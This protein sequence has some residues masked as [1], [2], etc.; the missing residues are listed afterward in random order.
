MLKGFSFLRRDGDNLNSWQCVAGVLHDLHNTYSTLPHPVSLS[1]GANNFRTSSALDALETPLLP[2]TSSQ[3]LKDN[4]WN[5][6]P[7]SLQD[8]IEWPELP[9]PLRSLRLP[10][11]ITPSDAVESRPGQ[12][13]NGV[14]KRMTSTL[15]DLE[16]VTV[17]YN[18]VKQNSLQSEA[19]L[20]ELWPILSDTFAG[21]VFET[22]RSVTLSGWMFHLRPFQ[23]F[24]TDQASTLRELRMVRCICD[25]SYSAFFDMVE[26]GL[27]SLRLT[28]VEIY[29]MRFWPDFTEEGNVVDSRR[30]NPLRYKGQP[31][32]DWADNWSWAVTCGDLEWPYRQY[33]LEAAM[34]QGRSNSM[35]RRRM[36]NGN[37]PEIFGEHVDWWKQPNYF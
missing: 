2:L 14:F 26:N 16:L 15:E 37:V 21:I 1:F 31:P 19:R 22:L 17:A 12:S 6:L 27:D 4:A 35:R 29:A 9:Q 18:G 23:R 33:E 13:L 5:P 11:D 24:L 28:G 25:E 30:P 3:D 7:R 36:E 8:Q 32:E 10:L 34:L 20:P